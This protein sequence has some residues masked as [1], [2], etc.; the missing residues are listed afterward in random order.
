MR[1]GSE[2]EATEANIN[3]NTKNTCDWYFAKKI[4]KNG[5]KMFSNTQFF[6][7]VDAYSLSL[8]FAFI[9]VRCMQWNCNLRIV[10]L[11][12]MNVCFGLG[13]FVLFYFLPEYSTEKRARTSITSALYDAEC[14]RRWFIQWMNYFAWA[15]TVEGCA[16]CWV[17]STFVHILFL[18]YFSFSTAA[19]YFLFCYFEKK[20]GYIHWNCRN[21]GSR[22]FLFTMR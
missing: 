17:A 4:K 12:W 14:A 19:L 18:N 8:R 9:S 5:S 2:A 7:E 20:R 13:N 6:T 21:F 10:E 11:L 15:S 3:T 22:N 16:R 1:I